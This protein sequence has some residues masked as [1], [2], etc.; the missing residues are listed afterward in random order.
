[1]ILLSV[2]TV[3]FLIPGRLLESIYLQKSL[4]IISTGLEQTGD[5]RVKESFKVKE[6]HPKAYLLQ[7]SGVKAISH[8]PDR[9]RVLPIVPQGTARRKGSTWHKR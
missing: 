8:T 7:V 5:E 6:R 1:M 9:D 2:L 3:N 4:C